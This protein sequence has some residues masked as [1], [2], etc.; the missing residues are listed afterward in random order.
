[1]FAKVGLLLLTAA[2]GV[3]ADFMV[4]TEPPIPTSAIPTF[5]DLADV[6]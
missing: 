3:M 1:M 4:Y 5:A 2:A 6:C